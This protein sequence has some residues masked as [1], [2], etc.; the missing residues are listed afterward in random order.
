QAEI[1]VMVSYYRMQFAAMLL[2]NSLVHKPRGSP[3]H[4]TA[5][6]AIVR[7]LDAAQ[8]LVN[9]LRVQR[10]V[11]KKKMPLAL[12]SYSYGKRIFDLGVTFGILAGLPQTK[13][14]EKQTGKAAAEGLAQTIELLKDLEAWLRIKDG[15]PEPQVP[16]TMQELS[17]P[18][19][20]LEELADRAGV[21]F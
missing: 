3:P 17:P 19:R 14:L 9:V 21:K 8:D 5:T 15:V 11:L 1:W 12:S 6:V 20:I 10:H 4:A 2:E 18:L 7:L 13:N 16:P